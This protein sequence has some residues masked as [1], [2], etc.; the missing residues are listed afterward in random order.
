MY[1]KPGML[2]PSECWISKMSEIVSGALLCH[3][4]IASI[5]WKSRNLGGPRLCGN[6]LTRFNGFSD[7]QLLFAPIEASL[8]AGL[9]RFVAMRGS[10]LRAPA[11]L[12]KV[13]QTRY[14][15]LFDDCIGT[16]YTVSPAM[17]VV[18]LLLRIGQHVLLFLSMV[19]LSVVGEIDVRAI[20]NAF[21]ISGDIP[22]LVTW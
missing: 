1:W 15:N 2:S 8:E 21:P 16:C 7:R 13:H 4:H 19:H 18:F 12:R 5:C 3:P 17:K 9:K 22:S 6:M 10:A 11:R 20:I 14:D